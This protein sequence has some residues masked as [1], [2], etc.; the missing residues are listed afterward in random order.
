MIFV[1]IILGA[2]CKAIADTL[3]HHF[4]SSIFRYMG[5]LWDPQISWIYAKRIPFTKYPLDA[6]HISNSLMII[7][8]CLAAFGFTW[9]VIVAGVLFNI[10]FNTFYNKL[11]R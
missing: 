2:I 4:H 8:F 7:F 9:K 11:L 1:F 5:N 10:V 6:W 3:A